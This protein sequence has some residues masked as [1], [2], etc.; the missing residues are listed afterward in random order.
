MS[1]QLEIF[2]GD[3]W[4][5]SPDI[6][7][8]PGDD[9]NGIGGSPIAGQTNYVWTRVHNTG[10]G[11]ITGGRVEFFWSNPAT[12]VLRSNSP[13]IGT[14]FVD[15]E[16][17]ETKQVL[18]VT[19][20]IPIIV[21]NGHECIVSEIIHPSDPLPTPL[22]DQFDPFSFRQV[23]QRNL[24]VV[25]MVN[26]KMIHIPI[27]I[28]SPNRIKKKSIISIIEEPRNLKE[29]LLKSIGLSNIKPIDS[30]DDI[31]VGLVKN[32][33][34]EKQELNSKIELEIKE[35]TSSAIFLR[36]EKK[37]EITSG[38]HLLNVI[39]QIDKQIIGGISFAVTFQEG[40]NQ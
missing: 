38:Y 40:I 24:S 8:V 16:P 21:N 14:S 3:P 17:S 9:P 37:Q 27:Q 10:T 31:E 34:C 33:V 22:P 4:W 15:L 23:A 30:K 7:V 6:W 18:C 20:W 39:E 11:S 29:D 25:S 26:I 12:G 19:P 2:D 28:S 1:T 32:Q 5:L 36:I 13:L 35:N